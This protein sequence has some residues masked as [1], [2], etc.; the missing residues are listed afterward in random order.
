MVRLL[1]LVVCLFWAAPAFA[2]A[3]QCPG[4]AAGW[5]EAEGSR[6]K[7]WNWCPNGQETVTWSGA[8][9]DGFADG[10]G[11]NQWFHAGALVERYEGTMR[12]GKVDG[13]GSNTFATGERYEGQ[14]R[15]GQRHGRGV[16]VNADGSRYEGEWRD[17]A[18]SGRGVMTWA[19]GDRYEGDWRDDRRTGRGLYIWSSARTY[20]GDGSWYEGEFEDGRFAGLGI[21]YFKSGDWYKGQV[22]QPP[23]PRRGYLLLRQRCPF[24]HMAPG[25]LYAEAPPDMDRRF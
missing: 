10:A 1:P 8:C 13:R 9:V 22:A 11:V 18:A 24:R 20:E 25:L 19:N 6:C 12:A 2:E 14:W 7:L 3:V 23:R 17:N 4:G 15:D 21:L 16:L 5:T